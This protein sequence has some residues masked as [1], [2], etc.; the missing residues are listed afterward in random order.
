MAK[1]KGTSKRPKK[2]VKFG[3]GTLEVPDD[4]VDVDEQQPALIPMSEEEIKDA[5]KKLAQ[6][7]RDLKDLTTKHQGLRAEMKAERTAVREEMD[8]VATSIR[9]QGR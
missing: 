7:V 3:T 5:G 1:K 9:Q 8:A 4:Q 2:T 6:L